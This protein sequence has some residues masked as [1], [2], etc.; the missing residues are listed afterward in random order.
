MM[1]LSDEQIQALHK[2]GHSQLE[3]AQLRQAEK[4]FQ[5]L[6]KYMPVHPEALFGLAE[7]ARRQRKPRKQQSRL[8]ELVSVH[9]QHLAGALALARLLAQNQPERALSY[10]ERA[11]EALPEQSELLLQM[12]T[13]LQK[14]GQPERARFY[15]SQLTLRQPMGPY[16]A[17]AW[18]MLAQLALRT[19]E[20]QQ[21]AEAFERAGQLDPAIRADSRWIDLEARWRQLELRSGELDW[22]RIEKKLGDQA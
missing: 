3:L 20:L 1:H 6:L 11:L 18:V 15:L 12:A 5:T 14:M 22:Q 9:P 21:A 8:E 4:S 10:L 17:E 2:L 7:V 16:T 13:C 19:G